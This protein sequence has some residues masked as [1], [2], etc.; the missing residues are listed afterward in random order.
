MLEFFYPD[1]Y[2]RN[3]NTVP[4][5]KL[6]EKNI[7]G[8]IFDIDN[9]LVPFDIPQPTEEIISFFENLKEMGFK[10]CLFSNNNQARV[11][12]FN[13]NLGLPAIFKAR[14]PSSKGIK[15]ALMLLGTTKE[16]TAIIGDQIFTDVW[17]GNRQNMITI[18]VKP[19]ATRDEFTVKL[20]RG[21]ERIV[22]KSYVRKVKKIRQNRDI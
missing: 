17:C 12:F 10:I 9:T 8:L 16:N 11:E 7:K 1:M 6:L 4:Y 21:I 15:K 13:E 20:K 22:V 18:L 2:V 3:I 14:K 5:E 19:V